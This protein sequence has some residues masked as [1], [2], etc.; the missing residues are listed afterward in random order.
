MFSLGFCGAGSLRVLVGRCALSLSGVLMMAPTLHAASEFYT[1]GYSNG[2]NAYMFCN[3][4]DRQAPISPRV[5]H[6]TFHP[7]PINGYASIQGVDVGPKNGAG[8]TVNAAA[9]LA[10]GATVTQSKSTAYIEFTI[11]S[12]AVNFDPIDVMIRGSYGF[13]S[14]S[15]VSASLWRGFRN[16]EACSGNVRETLLRPLAGDPMFGIWGDT[17]SIVPY[18]KYTMKLEA[19]AFAFDLA[20]PG[21]MPSG[22]AYVDPVMTLSTGEPLAINFDAGTLTQNPNFVPP[23]VIPEPS[24][25]A[26]AACGVPALFWWRLRSAA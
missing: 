5:P 12:P 7:N 3:L 18:T 13:T 26:L 8:L 19:T 15:Q 4:C 9:E 11:D 10:L 25:W 22:R 24:T 17:V 21:F 14:G 16:C 20:N 2:D 6:T 23:D 1:E